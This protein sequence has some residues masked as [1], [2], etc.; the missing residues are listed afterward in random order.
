MMKQE[1]KRVRMQERLPRQHRGRE[2]ST[3]LCSPSP[4]HSTVCAR[5]LHHAA[6]MDSA[7]LK[8][9]ARDRCQ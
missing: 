1:Q 2:Q 8:Q 7:T 4:K 3:V 6:D 9:R 5:R